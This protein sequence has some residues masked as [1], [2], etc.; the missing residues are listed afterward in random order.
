MIKTQLPP[1]C[2]T[3]SKL[4]QNRSKMGEWRFVNT[5]I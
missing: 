4:R 1:D 2:V 3:A 5:L